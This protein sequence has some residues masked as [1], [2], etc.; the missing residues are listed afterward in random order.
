MAQ[1]EQPVLNHSAREGR[2][3]GL[4]WQQLRASLS[5]W[6]PAAAAPDWLPSPGSLP[7]SLRRTLTSSSLRPSG[8]SCKGS[9]SMEFST[10]CQLASLRVWVGSPSWDFVGTGLGWV[11]FQIRLQGKRSLASE[12]L[13]SLRSPQTLILTDSPTPLSLCA[14][15]TPVYSH[16]G[17]QRAWVQI[18]APPFVSPRTLG[19]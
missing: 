16:R 2:I 3:S 17:S 9:A 18:P 15:L 13:T 11:P 10:P 5:V 7:C 14:L 12:V 19:T 4:P 8:R 1:T 6:P